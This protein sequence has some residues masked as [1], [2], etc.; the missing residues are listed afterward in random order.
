MSALPFRETDLDYYRCHF[1]RAGY[2]YD[3]EEARNK[4]IYLFVKEIPQNL[5]FYQLERQAYP[6]RFAKKAAIKANGGFLYQEFEASETL[7]LMTG[8]RRSTV[9][10]YCRELWR[11][12]KVNNLFNQPSR[13][14][15][16]DDKLSEIM[17]GRKAV[18]MFDMVRY[19]KQ[20]LKKI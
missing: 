18:H 19:L 8:L 13:T 4:G 5:T 6:E 17:G 2:I 12:I 14:I 16:C 20:N 1:Q 9:S 11:Y 7:A 10:G 3:G 15:K